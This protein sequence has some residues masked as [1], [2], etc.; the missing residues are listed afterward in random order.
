MIV[1]GE[2]EYGIDMRMA[3]SHSYAYRA[4]RAG[5][6]YY[7]VGSDMVFHDNQMR[8]PIFYDNNNTS[9]Y[10]DFASLSRFSR[11]VLDQSRINS[12]RF[13]VGHYTPGETVFEFDTAWTNDQLQ[14][15]FNNGNVEWVNDSSS[16]GGYAIRIIGGV[17][18]GGEYG[19]GFPYIPVDQDD[20]FYMECWIR[21]ENGSQRH[22]MGSID[23][24][25]GFGS[26]GGNPGSF[27]YWTMSNTLVGTCWTN[28]TGYIS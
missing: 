5:T 24:N 12:S 1:T 3:G 20:I 27:G 19:S 22:Y 17:S 15:Y 13:P 21:S 8:S 4:L 11:L 7:R 10:G 2:L 23:Y 14:A 25:S 26:L 28:V 18:V 9:Y 16:P 6:E